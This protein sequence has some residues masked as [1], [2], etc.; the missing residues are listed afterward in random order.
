MS[1]DQKI[2]KYLSE[3]QNFF[4][5]LTTSSIESWFSPDKMDNPSSGLIQ[6]NCRFLNELALKDGPV[7]FIHY[8]SLSSAMNILNSGVFRLYNCLNL[9]DPSEIRYLLKE[10]PI[11]FSPEEIQQFMQDHF[12]L[13]GCSYNSREDEDFNLWR[14]YGDF[15]KGIAFVFEV[16]ETI[17]NWGSVFLQRV[18]YGSESTNSNTILK[19]LKFHKEWNDVNNLFENKPHFFSLL[20]AGVKNKIWSVEK[21]FRV[22]AR[23]PMEKHLEVS[24]R[25]LFTNALLSKN[26]NHEYK[27]NGKLVSYVNFPI[28]LNNYKSKE[29]LIT[30]NNNNFN[31]TDYV[32]NLKI[33]KI[34]L[35]PNS[36][37][38]KRSDFLDYELWLK[39]KMN[40]DFEVD[41][42]S[43]KF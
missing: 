26:L 4:P 23:I 15:G 34:I 30:T 33:K 24:K 28:H 6:F 10:S 16:D 22:I 43:I 12:V 3:A 38:K 9:N 8:T 1:I 40:Y 41:L 37:F 27:P 13:S 42:S 36:I 19:Y 39:Q 14:L 35:G 5:G 18:N 20:S 31:P 25:E 17:N 29:E 21:E 2:Q 7:Q 11:D 32:P